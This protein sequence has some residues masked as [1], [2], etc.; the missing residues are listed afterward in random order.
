MTSARVA[1]ASIR[2]AKVGI[3]KGHEK[4]PHPVTGEGRLFGFQ[5]VKQLEQALP[6]HKYR[7]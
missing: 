3:K 7:I 1:S 6:S 2:L 5:T 4:A